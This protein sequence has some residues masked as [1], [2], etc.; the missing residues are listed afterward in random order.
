MHAPHRVEDGHTGAEQGGVL[1]GVDFVW[2]LNASFGPDENVL[3][4][5]PL[6]QC[7]VSA[8]REEDHVQPP[9]RVTPLMGWLSHM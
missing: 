6:N 3:G 2:H 1:G 4:I 9:F 7:A 5:Y 8:G